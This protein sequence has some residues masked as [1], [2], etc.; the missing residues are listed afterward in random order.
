MINPCLGQDTLQL[1]A[2]IYI[3]YIYA[4]R[5]KCRFNK[6]WGLRSGPAKGNGG[7]SA[8]GSLQ[9]CYMPHVPVIPLALVITTSISDLKQTSRSAMLSRMASPKPIMIS[10][11]DPPQYGTLAVLLLSNCQLAGSIQT[12]TTYAW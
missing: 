5:S 4:A 6:K 9:N 7:G 3:S 8:K 2:Y 10:I 1:V 12:M 11:T